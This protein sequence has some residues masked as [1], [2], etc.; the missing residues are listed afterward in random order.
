[1]V[2]LIELIELI[3]ILENKQISSFIDELELARNIWPLRIEEKSQ[4]NPR[5]M[6]TRRRRC[7]INWR[8]LEIESPIERQDHS[9]VENVQR[10]ST[11]FS[12]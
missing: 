2:R 7:Q 10:C 5:D 4:H 1:M 8:Y 12:L 11:P 9:N 6:A 3:T